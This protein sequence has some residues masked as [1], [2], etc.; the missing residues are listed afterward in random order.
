MIQETHCLNK[1]G[2]IK[3]KRDRRCIQKIIR[4]IIQKIFSDFLY[5]AKQQIKYDSRIK[6]IFTLLK[7]S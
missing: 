2:N 5:L 1:R 4:E 7:N 6:D 3:K